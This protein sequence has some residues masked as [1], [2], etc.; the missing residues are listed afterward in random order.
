MIISL[1]F[2]I[3][4][5]YFNKY[6]SKNYSKYRALLLD[7]KDR[8][9]KAVTEVFT[10]IRFIKMNSLENFF[11]KKIHAIKKEELEWLR[12]D[13]GVGIGFMMLNFSIP[14]LFL[15][16]TFLT[17][18]IFNGI[19]TVSFVFTVMMI[20]D[21]FKSDFSLIPFFITWL[22]DFALSGRR[23]TL[24]LLS[25]N[26]NTSYIKRVKEDDGSP[27]SIEISNGSFYWEDGDLRKCHQ[28]EKDR[29]GNKKI[30]E[31]DEF[32]E[33]ELRV[34]GLRSKITNEGSV[35]SL[36]ET[37]GNENARSLVEKELRDSLAERGS[38]SLLNNEFI[39]EELYQGITFNLKDI[40]LKIKKGACV[41]I[42]GSVGSGKSSLLSS[43]SG[44]MYQKTGTHI[45]LV[46]STAYVSQR[47]WIPSMT[48]K[49]TILFG[50]EFNQQRYE[51]SIKYSCM[52]SDLEI[53]A[54][55][56]ETMLGEKG[57]NLS[58]G[59]K[60][61][62]SIARAMYSDSDIYLFDDPISALDVHV[63]KYVMEEGIVG[64]LKGKTRVVATHA[65]EY[66][67]YF[68]YIYIMENG[69]IVEE[70]DYDF[71][72]NTQGFL[73]MKQS[74]LAKQQEQDENEE[75]GNNKPSE[76][77]E[78][79]RYSGSNH[80]QNNRF[81]E[82]EKN[83]QNQSQGKIEDEGK[84][85]LPDSENQ[86]LFSEKEDTQDNQ[87]AK[88]VEDIIESEDRVK[89]LISVKIL[90]NWMRLTG[91][92][93]INFIL[94]ISMIPWSLTMAGIPWFLQYFASKDSYKH[95]NH[96]RLVFL[97]S[98]PYLLIF[99]IRQLL[100][101]FRL[102]IIFAQNISM[103]MEVNFKMTFNTIHASVNK[104]F[105]RIPV[106]R[107]LNRFMKDVQILDE[108]F[109]WSVVSILHTS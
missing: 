87:Q 32:S 30:E 84:A 4:M 48:V 57:V 107:L 50:G 37:L 85:R 99:A 86:S 16:V 14:S 69:E 29:I 12:Q 72:S 104:Y 77:E 53:L 63:G 105:D 60:I 1:S 47:A 19:F 109:G 100:F 21:I 58:G 2:L 13:F 26:I 106:G 41:G 24:F 95:M 36:L 10:N 42:I 49:E 18:F 44:E 79:P 35:V 88:L 80:D 34:I 81:T 27:Y 54:N 64:Y 92:Y 70:G 6:L 102:R 38:E 74:E 75:E 71:I 91:G 15:F 55:R 73:K 93:I 52:T 45:K 11:L 28:L 33:S 108:E 59:Q 61:R 22:L 101:Y 68:D 78:K 76:D 7:V 62:L 89:G 65:I 25:D 98:W 43:L 66:L 3:F 67:K 83:D 20:Y 97:F 51:D 46:G 23:I 82:N 90:K 103:S 96:W 94:L 39:G 31:E 40:N 5:A 17:Y 8:R 56:D 9:G